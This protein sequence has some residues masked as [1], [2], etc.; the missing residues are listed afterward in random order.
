[1]FQKQTRRAGRKVANL[2]PDPV[3]DTIAGK[4]ASRET[5]FAIVG[6]GAS[7]G[8]LEAFTQLLELLPA[9]SGMAFVLIQHLDPTRASFLTEAVGRATKMTV[10]QA[11]AGARVEPNHVYVIPPDADVGIA[12]GKLSLLARPGDGRAPHLPIDSFMRALAKERGSRAIGV[13]LSG[14]AS[15]GTEGLRSIKAGDGITLAQD[16]RSAKFAGMPR[17]AVE[18]GVVDYSLSI[19][20][21]AAELLR[22]SQ[23][24]Y[25]IANQTGPPAKDG[26]K[27]RSDRSSSKIFAVVR[28][29]VGVDFA[30]YKRPTIERRIARRMALAGAHDL[31]AY[32]GA[33]EGRSARRPALCPKTSSF[34]SPPSFATPRSSSA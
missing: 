29:V 27:G 22:L 17:S 30:E 13:I 2:V 33:L 3:K 21:L 6:V 8:G 11:E 10:R 26:S 24:P 28:N 25:V 18:A 1:M 14:T 16:P 20:G 9:D 34:T 19:P 12:G 32:L 15:D 7:A 23:H 31:P 5:G 4:R